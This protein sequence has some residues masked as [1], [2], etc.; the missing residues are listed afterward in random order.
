MTMFKVRWKNEYV[1]VVVAVVVVVVGSIQAGASK[2][3]PDD[4]KCVTEVI[5]GGGQK[6]RKLY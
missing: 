3:T 4:A 1:V 2:H 6:I 5:G